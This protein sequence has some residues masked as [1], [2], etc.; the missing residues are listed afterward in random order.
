M[1]AEN[2]SLTVCAEPFAM[3]KALPYLKDDPIECIVAVRFRETSNP[4]KVIPP[5]GRCREFITDYAP[6]ADVII[7]DENDETLWKVAGQDLLPFK[8]KAAS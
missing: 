4:E 5:C 3:E 7:Y 8:Y 2:P 1:E 6:D